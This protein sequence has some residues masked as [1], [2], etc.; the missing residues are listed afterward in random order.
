MVGSGITGSVPVRFSI[1]ALLGAILLLALLLGLWK[2]LYGPYSLQRRAMVHFQEIG[3]RVD[4]VSG[5]PKWLRSAVG[6]HHF[7]NVVLISSRLQRVEALY[8]ADLGVAIRPWLRSD[9][10]HVTDAD[11]VFV[12]DLPYL[13]VLELPSAQIGDAGLRHVAG[14]KMLKVLDLSFTQVSDRGLTYVAKVASLEQLSIEGLGTTDEGL[15][16]LSEVKQLESL[17]LSGTSIT[18]GGLRHVAQLWSLKSLQ[19][20]RTGVSDAGM[21]LLRPLRQLTRVGLRDTRVTDG[22]LAYFAGMSKLRQLDVRGSGVTV[23][24]V[25]ILRAKLPGIETDVDAARR[26]IEFFKGRLSGQAETIEE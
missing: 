4:S 24:G 18:D 20:N 11:M 7:Q 19:L 1:K 23:D 16:C 10:V 3:A 15:R 26:R 6:D 9:A 25:A 22:C 13:T 14:H 12:K 17:N 8:S 5:G 21:A 2:A